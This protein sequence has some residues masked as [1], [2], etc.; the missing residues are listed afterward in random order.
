MAI[1]VCFSGKIGS[2]K[3]SVIS[4]LSNAL[5]WKQVGFGQYVRQEIAR[6][7]GDPSS[8]EALQ[9]FGQRCV[10]ADPEAFCRSLLKS[11]DHGPGENLLVD[12]VRHVKIFD[13]L[14]AVL[15]P[16]DVRLVHLSL[17]EEVQRIRV[18]GRNESADLDRA[19]GHV[20]EAEL[21]SS[22]PQR[23]DL[24]V[25]SDATFEQVIQEC[26]TAIRHWSA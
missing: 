17:T 25:N 22:L 15:S 16:A 20:V 2:G 23:A 13:V 8:R 18:N 21:N 5:G 26:L 1:V 14:Q 12:G 24:I 9:D 7:G 11:A 4:E 10:E 3:S 19:R 6:L